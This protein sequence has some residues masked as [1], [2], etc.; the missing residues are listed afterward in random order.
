MGRNV[1]DL[2]KCCLLGVAIL[3]IFVTLGTQ[4][5][6]FTRLLD[7]LENSTIE[8]EI[9][10]QAGFTKYESKKM[11]ILTYVSADDFEKYLN[12]ADVIVAHGGVGTIMKAL[13][14]DKKV[15]ACARLAKYGEHQN[16]HQIQII[17][18]FKTHGYLL[19][20]NEDNTIDA[21]FE[22]IKTFVPKKYKSNQK[23]FLKHL[24][25]AIAS[26]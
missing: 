10:V 3:M 26:L 21:C 23:E 24:E 12:E 6:P 20:L 4:D 16:D 13:N 14:N 25:E 8:D 1:K 7:Y 9:I 2:S 22:E 17:N 18:N 15:I 11:N 19:E 5:K